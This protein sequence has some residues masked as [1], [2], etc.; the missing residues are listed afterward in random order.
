[1]ATNFLQKYITDTIKK[2]M[3]QL[4]LHLIG[5]KKITPDT[6]KYLIFSYKNFDPKTTLEAA[7]LNGN[8]INSGMRADIDKETINR[9][10]DNA[11]NYINNLEQKTIADSGRA[12]G[13][14]LHE[15]NMIEKLSI[16][17]EDKKKQLGDLFREVKKQLKDQQKKMVDAADVIVEHELNNAQAFGTAD[18]IMGM[19]ASMGIE[20]PTVYKVVVNDEKLCKFCKKLHLLDDGVTPKVYK[21]SELRA[22]PGD[23]KHPEPSI[24]PV[25]PRCRCVIVFL[26]PN[27]GFNDKG[28][29]V[30]VG[31]G[32]DEYKKQRS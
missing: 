10:E 18:G 26:S 3:A 25:H 19:S 11:L 12:I 13:D 9:L 30:Y 20:D 23:W 2:L 17:E 31:L 22:T 28:K 29:I 4:K 7:Y 32:H 8:T 15:K 24:G 27:F 21:M 16:P 5:P 6:H 1:M 14:L